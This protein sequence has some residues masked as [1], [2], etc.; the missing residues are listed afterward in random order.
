M[1]P[2]LLHEAQKAALAAHA[3]V[4]AAE[5]LPA[6]IS[7]PEPLSASPR[8]VY[9]VLP[10]GLNTWE[11]QFADLLDHDA[12]GVVNWWHRNE[13]RQPWSVNVLMPDGRGF[14]PD[15]VIGIE[16]R[17]T[18]DNALLADPKLNY[19][20]EDEAAKVLAQHGSYGRVLILYLDGVRWMVVGQDPRTNRPTLTHEFRLSDAVGF[21]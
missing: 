14:F 1:R 3:E 11:R 9:G 2:E 13:P 18:T 12:N 10:P 6:E 5:E 15:F 4:L 17:Q 16:G 7:S 20:R 21:R 19:Q 8:N